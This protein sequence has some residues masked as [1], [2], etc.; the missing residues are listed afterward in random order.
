MRLNADAFYTDYKDIQVTILLSSQGEFGPRT[1][2]AGKGHIQGLEA[3]LDA[4][5]FQGLTLTGGLGFTDAKY[6]RLPAG[7]TAAGLTLSSK[8][9]QTSKWTLNGSVDYAIPVASSMQLVFRGDWAY[10]SSFY[11]AA[12]NTPRVFQRGYSVVNLSTA[13]RSD[14]GWSVQAGIRNLFDKHYMTAANDELTGLGY[15]EGTFAPPREWYAT[16]RYE[17]K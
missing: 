1:I 6:D 8:L 10:R 5:P 15:A 17:F 12:V 4:R 14:R 7:A 3:E 16:L 11:L 13:L 9:P 2:N